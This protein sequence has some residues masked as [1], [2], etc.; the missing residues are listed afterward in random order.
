MTQVDYDALLNPK[1]EMAAWAIRTVDVLSLALPGIAALLSVFGGV[2]ALSDANAW[3]AGLA[4]A[5]GIVGA[6][7]VWFTNWASRIRDN[8]LAQ[9]RSL[10]A[11]SMS[12]ASDA[13]TRSPPSF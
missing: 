6:F 5:G 8:R 9:A 3:A 11:V 7:G 4:I 13:L 1:P 10:G 2:A 12:M